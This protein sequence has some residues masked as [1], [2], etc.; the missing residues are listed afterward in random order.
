[1]KKWLK[2]L[3]VFLGVLVGGLLICYF[4]MAYYYSHPGTYISSDGKKVPASSTEKCYIYG[5][6]IND[7]YCTGMTV[8]QVEKQL[9][10]DI[11]LG[12]AYITF[13]GKRR[14]LELDNIEYSLDYKQGLTDCLNNQN[15]F[16]WP[17]SLWGEYTS[18]QIE[19][20]VVYAEDKL[21]KF[22]D[23][24][25]VVEGSDKKDEMYIY[26]GTD[27]YVLHDP[28]KPKLDAKAA[29]E[30][31]F[32]QLYAGETDIVIGDEFY[33][34]Y[35]YSDSE[36]RLSEF[37]DQIEQFQ[38]RY[39]AYIFGSEKKMVS[40]KQWA[41]LLNTG[42]EPVQKITTNMIG[43]NNIS[44][45]ISDEKAVAFI[46]EFLDEYNTLNNRYFDAHNGARVYVTKG[47]YGNKINLEKEEEWFK[48]FIN[49]TSTST[50]R[51]PEYLEQK[52]KYKEKNDFGNTFIEISIDE[53]HMWYYVDGK[54]YVE[55]DITSGSLANGG[56]APRVCAVYSIIP[57]KWLNG[58]TWHSFVKYWV[59]ID[60]AIGIHDASWRSKYG[61]TEYLYN[62]SHGCVNTP[63]D[64]MK[65][66]FEHVEI[67]TPVIVYSIEKNGVD[68]E[69]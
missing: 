4:G 28:C 48:E 31:V 20:S 39:V 60:G 25:K 59:A 36:K 17:M 45:E 67:G 47:T 57:N 26:L 65:K 63:H 22:L 5:T 37:F 53:Q 56:T 69:D 50:T 58:P 2:N 16:M 32:N 3:L 19:P 7:I 51:V 10:S 18:Y 52:A 34:E 12:S 54:V 30:Y 62:G 66:I 38:R 29:R 27:G 9:M 1:M 41:E 14:E 21:D 13:E 46:D 44:F 35:E 43:A 40:K 15:A 24:I 23:N 68:K 8:S 33:T 6:R 61:G 49:S 42:E 55:T 64:A 11:D